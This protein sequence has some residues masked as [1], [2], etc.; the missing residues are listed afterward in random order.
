MFPNFQ[1]DR[2]I[3]SLVLICLQKSDKCVIY[4]DS[5]LNARECWKIIG[6]WPSFWGKFTWQHFSISVNE[7]N[8]G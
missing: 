3:T 6:E 4:P 8:T 2:P 5:I 1:N 7:I